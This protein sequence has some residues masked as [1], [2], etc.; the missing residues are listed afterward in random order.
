MNKVEEF[1]TNNCDKK[2]TM[3]SYRSHLTNFFKI[4]DVDPDKYFDNGRDYDADIMTFWRSL[5]NY[6]PCTQVARISCVKLFFEEYDIILSNKT[7]K[8]LRR[9][10]KGKKPATIDTIP[11]N[12]Q[13]KKIISH[14]EAK[15]KALALVASSSGMRSDEILQLTEE[16]IDFDSNPV[17]IYVRAETT[18]TR[19][20][21]ITFMSNEAKESVLEWLKER[22]QYLQSAIAKVGGITAKSPD[23]DTIF[24]FTTTTANKIWNRLLDKSGFNERDKTTGYHR[25]H[26]HV[27]RKFFET[28]MSYAQV[29]EPVYQQ[30]EGHEGYLSNSYKRYTQ[31]ELADAYQKGVK[32]LL[33]FETQPDL[34][35]VN[36]ELASLRKAKREQ[37]QEIFELRQLISEIGNKKLE[38]LKEREK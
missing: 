37:D 19:T 8:K 11:T 1:L 13:L 34:T 14:G 20:A 23:D 35:D 4:M 15:A 17:K 30:L 16:D 5:G 18:K 25:M 10:L 28:R 36:E 21:R 22:D 7:K 12:N 3:K 38:T 24:C 2:S 27:L 31:K 32:S 9:K 29:P 33:V 26:F 6:T